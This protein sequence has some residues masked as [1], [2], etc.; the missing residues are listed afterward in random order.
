MGERT[1]ISW[2]RSTFNPWVGCTKVAPECDACYA[3]ALDARWH[4]GGHW[5]AG[6]ARQRTS[7]ALWAK[8]LEWDRRAA[9]E[10]RTGI[11]HD[12]WL[13]PAGF[14]PVFC[15]SLADVF[16]NEIE[17]AWRAELWA[18]IEAT[19]HLTWQLVTKRV[20]LVL[21]SVPA[22]WR[23]GFPPNVWLI[24]TAGQQRSFD[25]DWPK[26]AELPVAV[27]GVSVEPMLEWVRFPDSCRG[28]LHWAI[29]G[30]ESRQGGHRPRRCRVEWIERGIERSR[31]LGVAPFVKQLGSAA[32]V[33]ASEIAAPGKGSRADPAA[34]PLELRV[35]KFPAR[36]FPA[37]REM[38]PGSY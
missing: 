9:H 33:G 36:P 2:T 5:G 20:G 11:V 16:D 38:A 14:W 10:Q 12:G 37:S 4:G 24:A 3:E 18:L 25:R 28:R 27:R 7:A 6:A 26:L 31:E 17:P 1:A 35:Q 34:W 15:A 30:G 29:F 22:H 32:V 21:R 19:P 23:Q 8:P 13:G